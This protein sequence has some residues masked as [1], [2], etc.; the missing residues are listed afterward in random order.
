MGRRAALVVVLVGASTAQADTV[1]GVVTQQRSQA[2]IEGATVLTTHGAIATTDL[3]GYFTLEVEPAERDLTVAAP[4]FVARTVAVPKDRTAV[5]HVE[6]AP[7]VGGEV[8][9]IQG[10]APEQT[11]P[12]S[13]QL[14]ADEIRYLPGAGNDILRAVQSLPGVARI[15][16]SF[17]GLVLRGMSPRD[18][19][20]FLD[21]IEVPIA[22]HFG[23]VTSFY[24]GGMLSDIAL[25]SGGFDA[26]Y[27][28][29][30]GGIVRL[31]TREPRTDRWRVG[32]SVGLL[33]S[34]VQVEGPLPK[35]GGMIVGL[36][37]SYFDVVALPFVGTDIPLPSYWDFQLRTGWGD[38]KRR[39][40]ITPMLFTSIDVVASKDLAVTSSFVRAAVPYTRQWGRTTLHVVPWVG[41]NQLWFEDKEED[42]TFSRPTFPGGVRA[43]LTRDTA[44]GHVRGGAE[45]TGGYLAQTE[46]NRGTNVDGPANLSGDSTMWWTDFARWSELRL[47][48]DDG[49][50]ALKPGVR[51]ELYGL[52]GELVVD[53]RLNLHQQLTERVT[54]RQS[55]GRYHQ[56]PTPG[57]VD[58]TNGN[59]AL[60][61]SYVDQATLG[62]DAQLPRGVFAS[63]TGFFSY[64][65]HLGVHVRNPRPGGDVP[66]PDLGGLGPTFELLLEKQLGFAIYREAVGR[67]RSAGIEVL[68]K[69]NVD[70]WFAMLAYT[71]SIAERT[72]DPRVVDGWRPFELDQRHNLQLALS[73]QWGNWRFGARFQ[74]VSGNPYS[75]QLVVD[76]MVETYPWA[77]QLPAFISLDLR[78]DRHWHRSWANINLYADVQNV[79]NRRNIEGRDFDYDVLR[80]VDVRGLPII[81]FIGVEFTP[82][83]GSPR[84]AARAEHLK[85][86]AERVLRR[87]A[88]L[89]VARLELAA[90]DVLVDELLGA[91]RLEVGHHVAAQVA[92]VEAVRVRDLHADGL[93]HRGGVVVE[94]GRERE[95][96]GLADHAAVERREAADALVGD[97]DV[98]G[99]AADGDEHEVVAGGRPLVDDLDL[100]RREQLLHAGHH[101][102]P[103]LGGALPAGEL[104]GPVGDL[105]RGFAGRLHRRLL[106][107]SGGRGGH[108]GLVDVLV[109]DP[110]RVRVRRRLD[111]HVLEHARRVV[112]RVV[113]AG[114]DVDRLALEEDD[115]RRPLGLALHDLD[116][117]A[118]VRR[119]PHAGLDA[120]H[121]RD[122]GVD[123]ARD[124]QQR[125]DDRDQARHAP[126]LSQSRTPDRTSR[127]TVK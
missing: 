17:G 88:A 111:A 77:G 33:D 18:T 6:L 5:L 81:P 56:P 44:W 53:P 86:G 110:A 42:Q 7:A 103:L 114:Q 40:R 127:A 12:L 89:A 117:V 55:V 122:A 76:N 47:Q 121:D 54:L 14:T 72:D 74:A 37:R 69:R 16:F 97:A 34:S 48:L 84:G 23:G 119:L 52:S 11:K 15:P 71:L 65:R 115:P 25:T 57:D 32:G 73:K 8:I 62:V 123:A 30:Q 21:G 124:E 27:G 49:R 100:E 87:L 96:D 105:A 1:R 78:I 109:L 94:R 125:D 38:A 107:G 75:P 50:F 102:L 58:P 59:P 67:A 79:L 91:A 60:D 104:R 3:D 68:L 120:R 22:F 64:G 106:R 93:A 116:E 28:R 24:P 70:T 13:Y 95:H 35:G 36:R 113:G 101:R 63:I 43:E 82:A 98:R 90:R 46:V 80:E 126:I 39:G 61:S 19:S 112:R 92:V 45:L 118:R 10:K 83:K 85:E 41:E 31:T 51:A 2:P 108:L 66:D 20:V 29:A 9:E 4:G 99:F 26:S